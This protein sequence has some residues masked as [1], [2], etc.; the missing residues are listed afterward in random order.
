MAEEREMGGLWEKARGSVSVVGQDKGNGP[1]W[2]VGPCFR[3]FPHDFF[4]VHT[5]ASRNRPARG[6]RS[7]AAL[8]GMLVLMGNLIALG[9]I[10][11]LRILLTESSAPAGIY[12]LVAVPPAHGEL[13][14]ACLPP[15]VARTGLTRGYLQRGDCPAKAEPIAKVIGAI[16]GDGVELEPGWVAVN[17][18]KFAD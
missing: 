5:G 9:W 17:G 16:P 2:P 4:T 1:G 14:L 8:A 7:L 10:F 3:G 11:Q 6:R 18:M 15:A 13:V 12:H